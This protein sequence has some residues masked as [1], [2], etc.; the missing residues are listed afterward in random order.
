MRLKPRSD[1]GYHYIAGGFYDPFY[2]SR[3]RN[4]LRINRNFEAKEVTAMPD[5]VPGFATPTGMVII[6]GNLYIT[7]KVSQ[8]NSAILDNLEIVDELRHQRQVTFGHVLLGR[9]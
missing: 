1:I 3:N 2:R 6:E 8:S 4:I 7:F 9:E 5:F